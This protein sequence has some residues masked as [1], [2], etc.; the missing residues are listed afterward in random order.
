MQ[1]TNVVGIQV[2]IGGEA[3]S[4]GSQQEVRLE[5]MEVR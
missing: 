5:Q 1:V 4:G 3:A 2:N